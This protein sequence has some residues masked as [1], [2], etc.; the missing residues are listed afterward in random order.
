M[1]TNI[2]PATDKGM[3][4]PLPAPG[5]GGATFGLSSVLAAMGLVVLVA[6]VGVGARIAMDLGRIA[7]LADETN[8]TTITRAQTTQDRALQVERL[9]RLAVLVMTAEDVDQ[10]ADA[11]VQVEDLGSALAGG[12]AE[13]D[14]REIAQGMAIVRRIAAAGDRMDGLR[15]RIQDMLAKASRAIDQADDT[16]VATGDEAALELTERIADIGTASADSLVYLQEDMAL[17]ASRNAASMTLL[18]TLRDMTALLGETRAITA[19]EG[20]ERPERSYNGLARRL[21]PLL[22]G[23]PTGGDN[24]YVPELVGEFAGLSEVFS[25]RRTQLELAAE[26]KA[27]NDDATRILAAVTDRLSADAARG[28]R[29]T[30]R[31]GQA[32]AVSAGDIRTTGTV[33]LLGFLGFGLVV[34]L[35]LRGQVLKP[36]SQASQALE[37]MRQGRLDAEMPPTRLR[38]FEAIRSSLAGFRQALLDTKRLEAEKAADQQRAEEEKRQF[39]NELA[40]SFDRQIMDGVDGVSSS[41][42]EMQVTAQQMSATAEEASRQSTNV[43]TASEQATANVQ[44]VAATVEE[45]SA[46]IAEIGRQVSQSARITG[47]AVAEVESTNA[48]VLGLA[49]AAN[50]IGEV[51]TLINDIAGQTNLLALNA[52]IEAAR[53]GDAGKGFAVVAQEVKNLA[54]QTAKATEDISKQVSS[55]QEETTEAVLAIE[56]IRGIIAEVNDIATTISS[57]VEEQGVSTQEI[58]RNVQQAAKG[59]Q[60]VNANIENV[61]K[62]A[63]ETG[64]AAGQVLNAAQETSR[65]AESMRGEVDRFLKEI[66]TG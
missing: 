26:I 61:R 31:G 22:D 13:I 19:I 9:A 7:T 52:T 28:M 57:A 54:N 30:V 39:I 65:Q 24:E 18:M 25:M 15:G 4:T 45:L 20:L 59:T 32:I 47:N 1:N 64:S 37:D 49:E 33:L 55:V 21:P 14:D 16:L 63:D 60:D 35:F 34:A 50:R 53:A 27:M 36:V 23:L 10:R 66:R 5:T 29:E 38:E 11:L 2:K 43:A 62:A 8:A 56:K 51:V 48:T 6:I 40:D 17:L 46:S 58:A 44:T 41:A 12:D 42:S 3:D